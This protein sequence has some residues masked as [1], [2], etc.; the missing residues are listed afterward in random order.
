VIFEI[1]AAGHFLILAIT[2]KEDSYRGSAS[3][4]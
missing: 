4:T 1:L 3:L 2:C